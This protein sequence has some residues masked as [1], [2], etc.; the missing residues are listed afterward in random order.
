MLTASELL[1]ALALP[2]TEIPPEMEL[3]ATQAS[4][5]ALPVLQCM[6]VMVEALYWANFQPVLAVHDVREAC[7][8][9][10]FYAR[11]GST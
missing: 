2:Y 6:R 1:K 3:R 10:R 11:V 8:R 7:N 4:G 5:N 9:I